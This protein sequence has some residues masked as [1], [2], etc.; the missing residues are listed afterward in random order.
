MAEFKTIQS[1]VSSLFTVLLK[2]QEELGKAVTALNNLIMK[3]DKKVNDILSGKET[4]FST[5]IKGRGSKS[6]L[7]LLLEMAHADSSWEGGKRAASNISEGDKTDRDNK[8]IKNLEDGLEKVTKSVEQ[9]LH[10]DENQVVEMGG[11]PFGGEEDLEVWIE[12]N[13][14]PSFPFGCFVDIYSVLNRIS[15]SNNGIGSLG[16]LVTNSKLEI[17]SDE[18]VT[19]SE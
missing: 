6:E 19:I 9:I 8:R 1:Q 15:A 4:R 2:K 18:A 7:D 11:V 3:V 16:D 5:I 14:P 10:K 17:G 13:L 12:S